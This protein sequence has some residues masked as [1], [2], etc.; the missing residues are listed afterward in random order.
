M[1][2]C[3][4]TANMVV[5]LWVIFDH[6]KQKIWKFAEFGRSKNANLDKLLGKLASNEKF[7]HYLEHCTFLGD[8]LNC[9]T[10]L[11]EMNKIYSYKKN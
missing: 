9:A 5:L 2:H 6:S 3:Y 8:N 10:S 7:K 11:V 1:Q 4:S